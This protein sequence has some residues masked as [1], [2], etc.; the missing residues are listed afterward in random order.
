MQ[1]AP[2]GGTTASEQ[3]GVD[4]E[5]G[6]KLGKQRVWLEQ[7]LL[8]TQAVNNLVHRQSTSGREHSN[9]HYNRNAPK[10]LF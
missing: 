7:L 9:T 4:P 5:M 10:Q 3:M 2:S 8:S 1:V 6:L